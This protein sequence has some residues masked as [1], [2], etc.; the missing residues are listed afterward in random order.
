MSFG[1]QGI[2]SREISVDTEPINYLSGQ[3]GDED[4]T[5]TAGLESALSVL[6]LGV[7]DSDAHNAL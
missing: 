4:N 5:T 2:S 7:W 1:R 6:S 3:G